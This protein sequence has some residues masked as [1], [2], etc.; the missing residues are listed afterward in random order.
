MDDL[1]IDLIVYYAQ[2]MQVNR[3]S[4]EARYWCKNII[5]D[6]SGLLCGE[7]IEIVIEGEEDG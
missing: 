2:M 3:Q 6:L 4:E 7:G 5:R 1:V